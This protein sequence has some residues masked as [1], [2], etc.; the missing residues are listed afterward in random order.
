MNTDRL[1][2]A[3][4]W[5]TIAASIVAVITFGLGYMQFR[6]TQKATRETLHLERQTQAV[7]LFIKYNELMHNPLAVPTPT[8]TSNDFWQTNLAMSI[9][10][11]I[12]NLAGDDPGWRNTVDWMLSQHTQFLQEQGLN[13]PTYNPKFIEFVEETTQADVCTPTQ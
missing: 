8:G 3:S 1:Q 7:D 5:A 4:H 2:K 9:T 10:E 12:F 11:A 6:E 13:C